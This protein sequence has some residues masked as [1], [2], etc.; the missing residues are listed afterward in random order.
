MIRGRVERNAGGGPEPWITVSVEDANGEFH[1]I[2]VIVDTAFT[3]SLTLPE[4]LINRLALVNL[5][6]RLATLARGEAERFDYYAARIRW[7]EQF[8]RVEVFQ[9]I[10][11]F[12]LGTE[13]LEGCRVIVD[14]WRGGDVIIEEVQ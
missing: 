2:D 6:D 12:L 1:Q 9:S 8:R 5:G 3:G 7:H 13:L 4:A 10:D 14:A 11:Q